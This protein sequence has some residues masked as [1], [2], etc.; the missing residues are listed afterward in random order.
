MSDDDAAD[1]T[2]AEPEPPPKTTV[3]VNIDGVDHEAPP[4]QLVIEA[5]NDAG[6]YVPR[7]CYHSKAQDIVVMQM[8]KN[9]AKYF[10]PLTNEKCPKEQFLSKEYFIKWLPSIA[11]YRYHVAFGK[12]LLCTKKV[13]DKEKADGVYLV[14]NHQEGIWKQ[15]TCKE[16]PR[17]SKA[18]LAAIEAHELDFGAV[19]FLNVDGEAYI[20]EVNTA[21]GLE[22]ENRLD[23]YSKAFS[24]KIQ[25]LKKAKE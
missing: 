2:T 20:L 1:V 13:L 15:V 18:C 19:D 9:G 17:F 23:L 7:F 12:I 25:S 10:N 24:D 21:P 22:V 16:T 8:T 3:T 4:G 5:C 6:T 11:E 14:R